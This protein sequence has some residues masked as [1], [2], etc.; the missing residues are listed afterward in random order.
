MNSYFPWARSGTL[1]QAT[2]IRTWPL[3]NE[4]V[5]VRSRV[6]YLDCT[7]SCTLPCTPPLHFSFLHSFYRFFPIVFL[8]NSFSLS[9]DRFSADCFLSCCFS[10]GVLLVLGCQRAHRQSPASNHGLL[11]FRIVFRTSFLSSFFYWFL[12]PFGV[13][14][15]L[16][17]IT[18]ALLFRAS[19][20]N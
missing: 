2:Q 3:A 4:R 19:I 6:P 9:S 14:F 16:F 1:P 12:L 5:W 8:R 11:L 7:L 17:S 18:F 13:H 20:F 10:E 15:R